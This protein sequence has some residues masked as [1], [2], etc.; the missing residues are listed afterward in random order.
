MPNLPTIE[1]CFGCGACVDACAKKAIQWVEDANGFYV[2]HVQNDLCVECGSCEKKCPSLQ[3]NDVPRNSLDEQQLYAA[4]STDE[5]I[6]QHSASG[7]VFAQVATEFLDG[8]DNRIV[9]GA[10]LLD[11]STVKHIAVEKSQDIHLLQNAK[12]QQSNATGIYQQ[13]K[14]SLQEGKEVLFS[15]TP[16]QVA[17]LY[18]FL[19]KHRDDHHLYTMEVICHGVP[20]NYL[21][22]VALQ[23]NHAQ[24]IVAYRTKSQG[25][26]KGNRTKYMAANGTIVEMPRYRLDFHFRAYLSFHWLRTSCSTCPFAQIQRVADIT[27]GDFWGAN[28][29]KYHNYMGLSVITVNNDKGRQ[30][31]EQTKRLQCQPTT[32]S[33]ALEHN[34]NLYMPTTQASKG[35]NKIAAIKKMSLPCQKVIL[36][37]GFSNKWLFGMGQVI[38][39]LYNKVA[40]RRLRKTMKNKINTI[41]S[42][43]KQTQPKV[44]ILTTYF[45]ANFGAMLQP[46]ALKRVLERQGYD[47]EFIRY[48]QQAV[49]ESHKAF[50]LQRIFA[51]GMGAA[52][53]NLLALPFA[54]VQD[55]KMQAFKRKYLQTPDD[56]VGTI[57]QDKDY[58]L[59]GSDQIWNPINT[60]GFD[61]IYF[62]SFPTQHHAKKIAYAASGE[63]IEETEENA[64]YLQ[65]KLL[66]FDAIGVREESLKLKLQHMTT[67][68][69]IQVVVDP[70]L[71]ADKT[72]LDELPE[73]NVMKGEKYVFFYQLRQSVAFLPKIHAFARKKGCKLQVISST[74]KKDCLTYAMKHR[75]V[76]YLPAAGMEEFL[77]AIRH[78]DYVFTPSFHGNVFAI[79][80]N[81]PLFSMVLKDKL[82]NRAHD[83]LVTLGM[84]NRLV[85][86]ED[87]WDNIPPTSYKEVNEKVEEIRQDSMNFLTDNMIAQ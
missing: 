6:I 9:Y 72:I 64:Q 4:W 50:S 51:K 47:V 82:N 79:V 41:L 12:Y 36:Q 54:L 11:D 28:K 75:D 65:S 66:N 62:G 68:Q 53:G 26:A 57:P 18:T 59:F 31:I 78:A 67:I 5:N 85:T 83:L 81:R 42:Q 56:F 76:T 29:R 20:T 10:T 39:T 38:E 3:Q 8:G 35:A 55:S 58:Y 23:L 84:Q 87:E 43:V 71:L 7:G 14:K 15:G 44:G 30:L 2:P 21:A 22:Q 33:E 13:V 52:I 48:K 40:Q 25:W 27:M 86:L 45:A 61:D 60:N 37:Q 80:Y 19:G 1:R 34:Q 46:Y 77:G 49:Y 32:Y 24:K 70:T 74:P 63:C 73:K 69:D 16:C 17:A